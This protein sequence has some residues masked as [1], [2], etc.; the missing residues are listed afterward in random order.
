M[1]APDSIFTRMPLE[2]WIRTTEDA[3]SFSPKQKP[4][5]HTLPKLLR[6]SSQVRHPL[7]RDKAHQLIGRLRVRHA[8]LE[9]RH[10][11][12]FLLPLT[13]HSCHRVA[14]RVPRAPP[15][16]ARPPRLIARCKA[17]QLVPPRGKLT[18]TAREYPLNPKL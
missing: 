15:R 8:H 11:E 6:P 16:R 12:H 4:R 18:T 14:R 3:S 17:H 1:D 9:R 5:L 10:L 7:A 2:S 13:P